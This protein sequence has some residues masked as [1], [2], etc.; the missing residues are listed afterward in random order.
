MNAPI[1]SGQRI[2]AVAGVA[3][4]EHPYDESDVRQLTAADGGDV[5]SD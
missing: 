3:N 5:A 2:V 1:F 4:K